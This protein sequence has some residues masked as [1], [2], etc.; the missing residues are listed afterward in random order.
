MLVHPT[1]C[2]LLGKPMPWLRLP[3]LL[4]PLS[5]G[6]VQAAL[7]F[8]F[9]LTCVNLPKSTRK[10]KSALIL[11][12]A[13]TTQN[14]SWPPYTVKRQKRKAKRKLSWSRPFIFKLHDAQTHFLSRKRKFGRHGPPGDISFRA[15]P[16]GQT[17]PMPLS[18]LKCLVR[19]RLHWHRIRC[20][21]RSRPFR[22]WWRKIFHK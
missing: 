6:T 16:P 10:W 2:T 7:A 4:G 22:H 20:R 12:V 15:A 9:E 5:Y 14:D 13:V 18:E 19:A 8:F 3:G 17:Q 11:T 1:L 21:E